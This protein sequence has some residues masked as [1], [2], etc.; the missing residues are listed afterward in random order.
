MQAG[1]IDTDQGYFD[2]VYYS[3][4]DADPDIQIH[5]KIE[6]G[7]GQLVINCRDYPLNISGLRRA[8]AFAFD[9]SGVTNDILD[10]FAVEHDSVVPL[11]NAFCI[12]EEL[13]WHYYDAQPDIGNQIL[14]SLGFEI[15]VGTGFRNAPNGSAF[16]IAI[17]YPSSSPVLGAGIASAAV[18]ALNALYIDAEAQASDFSDY[19]NR[20]DLHGNY[21][22]VFYAKQYSGHD[23]DWLGYDFWSDYADVPY[24]NPSNFKNATFDAWRAQ[25]LED[26]DYECVFDASAEMQKIL[27]EN[28]PVVVVYERIYLQGYRTDSF[29]GFVADL[30]EGI[31]GQWSNRKVYPKAGGIMEGALTTA[32]SQSVD[33]FNH[34]SANT[35]AA[36]RILDNLYSSLYRRGPD[37]SP[38][39]DLASS[40]LIETHADNATVPT[41]HTRYTIDIVHNAIWSDG[42][43]LTA[44]DVAHTFI[45]NKESLAYGNPAGVSLGNLLSADAP[46]TYRVVIEFD[47]TSHWDFSKIAYMKVIPYHIYNEDTG[48]GYSGWNTLTN[49]RCG[50]FVLTDSIGPTYVIQRYSFYHYAASNPAPVIAPFSDISYEV[51]TTGHQIVWEVSDDNPLLYSVFRNG[52]LIDTDLW[53]GSDITVNIDGLGVGTYNYT[54]YLFD[55]SL[56]MASS[57]VWVTVTPRASGPIF[58]LRVLL[59]IGIG[60]AAAVTI[61]VV[62]VFRSRK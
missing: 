54:L 23:V 13:P 17:E 55:A 59:V 43:P 26:P 53:N 15:D 57:T 32:V 22:M 36:A 1:D 37:L 18:D 46:S 45:Y 51:G 8:F 31:S 14:E 21:D 19:M 60:V 28:V 7:Y 40:F 9:K 38:V 20:L 2:P 5:E 48:L 24:Q 35:V 50:P 6:N 16:S 12:E 33:T 61:A 47:S 44:Q 56:N 29:E 58:D 25:L 3:I 27:H 62:Y 30:A 4:I 41:G 10:S 49:V 39:A 11:P 42:M 52:T 34:F